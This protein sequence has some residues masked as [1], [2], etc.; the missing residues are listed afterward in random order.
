MRIYKGCQ[1]NKFGAHI[2]FFFGELRVGFKDP[3]RPPEDM[4]SFR[5]CK[6]SSRCA[7]RDMCEV[8]IQTPL[9]SNYTFIT[10]TFKQ[11]QRVCINVQVS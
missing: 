1:S 11:L 2:I 6:K 5:A 10:I 7:N 3:Y 8:I 9:S 4:G